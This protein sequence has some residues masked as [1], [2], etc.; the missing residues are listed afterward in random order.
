MAGIQLLAQLRDAVGSPDLPALLVTSS[1][2]PDEAQRAHA[3]PAVRVLP[4]PVEP[5]RLVTAVRAHLTRHAKGDPPPAAAV[6]VEA[7]T[8]LRALTPVLSQPGDMFQS[9]GEVVLHLL[10][11]AGLSTGLLYLAHRDGRLHL[12]DQIGLPTS[13][14]DR[15]ATGFDR[16]HAL[17][18]LAFRDEPQGFMRGDPDTERDLSVAFEALGRRWILA[19]PLPREQDRRGLLLLASDEKDLGQLPWTSFARELAEHFSHAV[20]L[21]ASLAHL[22][23]LTDGL[24]EVV[25]LRSPDRLQVLYVNQAYERVFGRSAESLRNNVDSWLELVHPEDRPAVVA[26]MSPPRR[27]PIDLSYRILHPEGGVRW[28]RGRLIPI[29]DA[30]GEVA[31]YAG[32]AEDVTPAKEAEARLV[33]ARNELEALTHRLVRVQEEERRMLA[34]ELHDEFGQTLTSL[35][36]NLEAGLKTGT[37]PDLT[38]LVG[39]VQALLERVQNLSLDLRPPMLDERGLVPA[40]LWHFERFEKQTGIHVEFQQTGM[41]PRCSPDTEITAF[42]IIQEA[43]TN[44]ARHAE[45]RSARVRL[46]ADDERIDVEIADEG[47]GF[48]PA[49]PRGPAT[50]LTGMRERAQLAD[51]SLRVESIPGRGSRIRASL[52]RRRSDTATWSA[53]RS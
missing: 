24:R 13:A 11:A 21:G 14:A 27:Q 20:R 7:L 18:A 30:S 33:A 41:D 53:E 25:W 39:Q 15:A 23:G 2:S 5:S 32:V 10:D 35:K 3:D 43:L 31:H 9:A 1:V 47:R 46:R 50:G 22:R 45:V 26:A 48:D 37:T 38:E 4:K 34:R 42:R 28:I 19:V 17:A 40:L 51:G 6:P 8:L 49:R 36:L 16:P 29:L 12:V 52:P 44:V